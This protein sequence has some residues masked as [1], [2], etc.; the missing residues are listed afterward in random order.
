M[1]CVFRAAFLSGVGF[2]VPGEDGLDFAAVLPSLEFW[3]FP[4]F[5]LSVALGSF[6]TDGSLFDGAG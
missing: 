2:A 5:D 3:D 4:A 6:L 1:F